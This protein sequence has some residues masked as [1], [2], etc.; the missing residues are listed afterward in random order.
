MTLT[1]TML[2]KFAKPVYSGVSN[3]SGSSSSIIL[4]FINDS[5]GSQKIKSYEIL[6]K[7]IIDNKKTFIY[8][9]K[10][11]PF[12]LS[13]KEFLDLRLEDAKNLQIK[14]YKSSKKILD[15]AWKKGIKHV[16]LCNGK[17]VY[18]SSENK[19]LSNEIVENIAKKYNK[20]FYVFSSSDIVEE[21]QWTK[22]S[23]EDYYPTL[24]L[25]I[26]EENIE[27]TDLLKT[28]PIYADFDTGN[29][30]LRI[31]DAN[32]FKSP[33]TDFTVLEMRQS[34]HL[35]KIYTFF[36]K[37]VKIVIKDE[38]NSIRSILSNVRLVQEWKDSALLQVSPNRVGFVGRD[39][40]REF[41]IKIELN[42]SDSSTRIYCQ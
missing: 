34:E 15:E 5:S 23:D 20:A 16:I 18:G 29:P 2:P 11:D 25:Y 3:S 39:L 26:G 4:P 12:D 40:I 30:Y 13:L 35:N 10:N 42:P 28:S 6:P 32:R 22:V 14:A 1:T 9:L 7:I 17:I 31:F 41:R 19:D 38:N 24:K 33:I 8:F 37:K 21:S 36:N 27:N